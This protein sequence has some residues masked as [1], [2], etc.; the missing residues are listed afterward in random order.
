MT[1]APKCEPQVEDIVGCK[2]ALIPYYKIDRI[3]MWHLVHTTRIDP[4]ASRAHSQQKLKEK[5]VR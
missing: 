1:I 4:L 5:G 2:E 3:F